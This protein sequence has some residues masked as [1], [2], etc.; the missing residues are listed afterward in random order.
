MTSHQSIS[1][2]GSKQQLIGVIEQLIELE[3]G[4]TGSPWVS[5]RRL[6]KLFAISYGLDLECLVEAGGYS[7]D[8]KNLLVDSRRFSL[9]NDPQ[10]RQFYVALRQRVMPGRLSSGQPRP[11]LRLERQRAIP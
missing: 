6:C 2:I 3:F 7:S 9:Y 10:P 5:K 4:R 1:Q 11:N 8:F